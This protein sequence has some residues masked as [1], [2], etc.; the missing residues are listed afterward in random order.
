MLSWEFVLMI[1]TTVYKK[2][3]IAK[4]KKWSSCK[5]TIVKIFYILV[6]KELLN[7]ISN[8]KKIDLQ[9]KKN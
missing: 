8:N 6:K 1:I 7:A 3:F 4:Q 5:H 2:V 9:L